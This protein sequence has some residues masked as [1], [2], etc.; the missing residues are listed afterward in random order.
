MHRVTSLPFILTSLL[1][2]VSCGTLASAP[3]A[4]PRRRTRHAPRR[5]A[6]DTQCNSKAA[7]G[8]AKEG[9]R[10]RDDGRPRAD[11]D[12]SVTECGVDLD[13]AHRQRFVRPLRSN[14]I[15][16]QPMVPTS[17]PISD[18]DRAPPP[19]GK[20]SSQIPARV[21]PDTFAAT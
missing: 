13:P 12:R 19:V 18:T 15:A 16:L 1:V 4:Q 11:T 8:H 10:L 2:L 17:R 3:S 9:N 14:T 6:Q 20:A 5:P 21:L 7:L